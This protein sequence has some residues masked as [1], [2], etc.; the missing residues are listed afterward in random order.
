MMNNTR[1]TELFEL[2]VSRNAS[3]AERDELRALMA[4][5]QHSEQVKDLF[6]ALWTQFNP[7]GTVFSAE[8]SETMLKHVFAQ[9]PAQPR[10]TRKTLWSAGRIAI[11]IAA[12]V[13]T[14][15][16]GVWFFNYRQ[17]DDRGDLSNMTKN[18]VAPGKYGATITLANGK[19]ITLSDAK[20]GV[21]I[22]GGAGL[23]Y[24]DNTAVIP[25]EDGE[26]L[27]KGLDKGSSAS[28]GMTAVTQK[29]QTYQFTLPDGTRVWLNAD[30]K[31]EFPASFASSNTRNVRLNGEGYFEVAKDKAHP[32]IV[33]GGGQQVKVLGTH[34][35]ISNYAD[36]QGVKT[37]LLEGSVQVVPA[38]NQGTLTL[39]P[40]QQ[41]IYN[42]Q[43]LSL[44]EV[45]PDDVVSWK[46]G[47]FVFEDE[48]FRT[49]M[50]KIARW[51]DLEIIYDQSVPVH[52]ELA[53]WVSRNSNL[54]T[55]LKRIEVASKL[56]FTI[57]GRRVTVRK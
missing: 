20:S 43:K 31:L 53:G 49:T 6:A 55:V 36:E 51:Y 25:G 10:A 5:E 30:S 22:G 15:V 57:E 34:F 11:S 26:I 21:V 9:A 2:Q 14:I 29:G 32:F 17:P 35:N 18:D 33:E 16:F 1:L 19:V 28:P 46:N 13:A 7:E 47:D 44:K 50:R 12:A 56:H 52:I 42:G 45:D 4:D 37:T 23:V 3:D 54:S 41:A 24:N 8:E 40:R 38:V 48:D 27:K 39:K